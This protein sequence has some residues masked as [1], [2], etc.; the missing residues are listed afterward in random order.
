MASF[1]S[2]VSVSSI[3]GEGD[4]KRSVMW[5]L[6]MITFTSLGGWILMNLIQKYF[7][8][9]FFPLRN[10]V[11]GPKCSF[12]FGQFPTI[13]KEPFMEPHLRWIKESAGWDIPFLH[14]SMMFGRSSL[15]IL[16][17]DIV[18]Q[19]LTA[20]YGKSPLRFGK[21]VDFLKNTLG[22]GLVTAQ[23]EHWMRHRQI[24]QPAFFT[25]VLKESLNACVPPLTQR[26]VKHWK[27]TQGRE[28]DLNSHLSSLTL[29]IIGKVAFSHEFAALDSV[30][31]WAKGQDESLSEVDDPLVQA[32]VQSFR[33][34][35]IG[36]IA[37]SLGL[38]FINR[39]FNPR[40][41][42]T[43]LA[44]NTAVDRV[45]ANAKRTVKD[46]SGKGIAGKQQRSLLQLLLQAAE[47]DSKLTL[48]DVELR[49][50]AKTFIFAGHETTSTWCYLSI[51]A[52]VTHPEIQERVFQDIAR[53]APNSGS[54]DIEVVD[55]ME[56]FNA[57]LQEVLRLH[58]P[59]GM[60]TRMNRCAETFAGYTIPAGTKLVMS[61]FLL[62][63]HPKYWKDPESF[64]PERWL[65]NDDHDDFLSQIRF[66]F[67]PFSAG[68]RNCIGQRFATVEAKLILAELIRSF[69]F[70]IAPSQK[71]TKF[72]FSNIVVTKTKPRLQIV[73]KSR[74]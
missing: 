34:T 40:T 22:E 59:V 31:R 71:D 25:Q 74:D 15:L 19:I 18:K 51:Y 30:E 38:P 57:F 41:K 8:W 72:T 55:K 2:S 32:L 42:Q 27:Q 26:L 47:G 54:L 11:P 61:T 39:Y 50:E 69:I 58:P 1:L 56:Y 4:E 17:K 62:H 21:D 45:I 12:L 29:D 67:L 5:R 10:N 64:Q 49:D 7:K 24:I 37:F 14:Y 28:I 6:S 9:Y 13:Q 35:I 33:P 66:A 36:T 52:L 48:N 68:G 46:E 23:G 65:N 70:R 60:Y 43:N 20:P 73:V 44:L 3:L 63:R 53:H 16:D